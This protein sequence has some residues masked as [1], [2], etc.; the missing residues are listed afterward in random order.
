M[1]TAIAYD[2]PVKNLIAELNKTGHVTHTAYRKTSVTF[3]HNAGRFSHE[4]VLA[5]WKNR[6][7][8]AHFDVDLAG[9]VAQYVKVNE[10]AWSTGT[11]EG[12][13]GSISIEMANSVVGGDWAVSPTTWKSAAR[14]A[15]WLFAKVIGTAPT[16]ANVHY[17]SHWASTICAGPYMQKHYA[18]LLAEVQKQY[19]SFM[20]AGNPVVVVPRKSLTQLAAEVWAG[21]W[22]SGADRAKRLTKAGYNAAAV[23]ALVDRGVGRSGPSA[24]ARKTVQQIAAEVIAGKWGNGADRI[25]RL[26]KAGYSPTAVQSEVNRR[27]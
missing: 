3:H 16:S 25:S 1:T 11:I 4:G 12:N 8:S 13:V 2:K 10:Y 19:R 5:I 15:G 18:E 20:S 26:K 9:A 6:P 17:H 24:P 14:L 21:K 23:Q 7:A 22:G 27:I